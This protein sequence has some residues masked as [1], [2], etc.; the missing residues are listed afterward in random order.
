ML[1]INQNLLTYSFKGF[2]EIKQLSTLLKTIFQNR[3][4]VTRSDLSIF[5]F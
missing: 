5:L 3:K 2:T 1:T 4:F